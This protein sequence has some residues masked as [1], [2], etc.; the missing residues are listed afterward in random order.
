M[1]GD[2]PRELTQKTLSETKFKTVVGKGHPLY[3]RA[4]SGQ[5]IAV[6][7]VLKHGFVS[8]THAWL[9]HVGPHQ[10]SDGWRDDQ[11]PR[12]VTYQTSSLTLLEKIVVSGK[13]IA[14]LPDYLVENTALAVIKTT[15]CPYHCTQTIRLI[16]RRP[17]E[18]GWLS[19]LF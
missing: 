7:D 19:Q 2:A 18:V 8:P 13:A 16:A 3:S 5:T 14:Y 6:Q 10:S 17:K 11:F 4:N 9:G 15:G 12:K 1:S